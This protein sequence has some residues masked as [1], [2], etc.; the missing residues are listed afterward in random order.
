MRYHYGKRM[1]AI[2]NY[3]SLAKAVEATGSQASSCLTV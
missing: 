2:D 1:T 3:L